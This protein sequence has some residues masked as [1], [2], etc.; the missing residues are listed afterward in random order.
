MKTLK[1]LVLILIP[2]YS[3]HANVCAFG[4]KIFYGNGMFN[5]KLEADQSSQALDLLG[6]NGVET[7]NNPPKFDLAYNKNESR[8][9]NV[10]SVA[11]QF[12]NNDYKA[13]WRLIFGLEIPP[14]ITNLDLASVFLDPIGGNLERMVNKYNESLSEGDRVIIVSHSQGNFFAHDAIARF[15]T[16]NP[17]P[18]GI[19]N[20]RVATPGL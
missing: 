15:T 10:L 1:I 7:P 12:V 6:L 19:G 17:G 9:L 16:L 13:A 2:I 8:L 4:T 20:A 11:I 18:I 14:P 3:S 5:T